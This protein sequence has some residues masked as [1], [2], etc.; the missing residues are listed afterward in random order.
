MDGITGDYYGTSFDGD[1]SRITAIQADKRALEDPMFSIDVDSVATGNNH[2][3]KTNLTFHYLNTKRTYSD[4]VVFQAALIETD[5]SLDGVTFRNVVRK[6][7]VNGNQ[8]QTVSQFTW[9]YND[10]SANSLTIP[11]D[12]ELD[13]PVRNPDKLYL[14]VF[15]HE[16]SQDARKILQSSLV[17]ILRKVGP[18]PVG[19]HDDPAFAEISALRVYPN[20]ASQVLNLELDA[21]L[22]R[23][24]TWNMVDQRGITV[25]SGKVNHDLTTPQEVSVSELANG[26]YFLQIETDDRKIY[27][28][29]VAVM[30]RN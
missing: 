2:Q 8:G 12:Y 4:P 18:E 25:L 19:I 1:Y 9:D 22:S 29:K 7:L 13:V 11:I 28:R 10:P 17:K 30:N 21:K 24:Y 5:I 26:I 20:P 14:A 16:R 15:A 6:L 3:L 23:D 27:F